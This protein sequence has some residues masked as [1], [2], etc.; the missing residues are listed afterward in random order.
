MKRLIFAILCICLLAAASI[1]SAQDAYTITYL[2]N[3]CLASVPT[4]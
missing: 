4:Y 3:N 1:A 2:G